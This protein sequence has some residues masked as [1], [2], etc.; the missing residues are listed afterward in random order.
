M[1]IE[2]WVLKKGIGIGKD[3]LGG[4]EGEIIRGMLVERG[5]LVFWL[6]ERNGLRE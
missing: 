5:V 2:D 4:F 1:S 3:G 6:G